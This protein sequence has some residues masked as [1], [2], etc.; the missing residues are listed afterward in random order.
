MFITT[1]NLDSK[2]AEII[3]AFGESLPLDYAEFVS[4]YG[5]GNFC[6]EVEISYPDV[7]IIAETFKDYTD[8]W[9]LDEAF[10][11]EDLLNTIQLGLSNDGDYIC[12]TK[13]QKEKVCVLPCHSDTV[14]Y[15]D[16][17]FAAV[18]SLLAETETEYFDPRFERE[19]KQIS[20]VKNS[21]LIEIS[22][23]HTD[24]LKEF[25]YDLA[26]NEDAQPIYFMKK[27]GGWVYFDLIYESSISVKFQETFAAE[28]KPII[29]F[30][31][32]RVK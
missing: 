11:K 16:T 17:F 27:I 24:F 20:L 6:G 31:E 18:E 30:L 28:A 26:I 7:E 15:F 12:V 10:T 29:D 2:R 19:I 9:K 1:D 32:Q 22:P 4:K 21:E 8:L 14:K 25:S 23:I 3:A 13:R 5:A